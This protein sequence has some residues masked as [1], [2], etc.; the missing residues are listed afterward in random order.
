MGPN[1]A[2]IP[3]HVSTAVGPL[4]PVRAGP[5]QAVRIN[6]YSQYVRVAEPPD[7]VLLID[8]E[9]IVGQKAKPNLM[10]ARVGVLI[11]Q[12]GPGAWAV[13][14]CAKDRITVPSTH[15]LQ[16]HNVTLLTVGA[17]K[18]AADEALLAEA[19]RLAHQGCRRFVVASNDSRFAQLAD[20][21]T[22]EIVVWETQK[23]R[24]VYAARASRIH[25]LQCPPATTAGITG[26]APTAAPQPE[27]SPAL[28]T[29]SSPSPAASQRAKPA[30]VGQPTRHVRRSAS[31]ASL[32]ADTPVRLAVTGLGLLTAG[33]IFG[34]GAA[35]GERAAHRAL[36]RGG[37]LL[38][39]AGTAA[40]TTAHG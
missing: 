24:P 29:S 22:L 1:Q 17:A 12:A 14:A 11:R 21:G 4:Q 23:M 26:S 7:V 6:P 34:V 8:I 10:A 40:A 32:H 37:I 25:R 33:L 2:V 36:R 31:W 13:A 5:P 20:L 9:N 3:L 39:R 19:Q 30:T 15:V 18:D 16:A 38:C 28:A 35:L 27:P